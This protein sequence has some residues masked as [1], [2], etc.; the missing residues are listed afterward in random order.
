M[1]HLEF[2]AGS[3]LTILRSSGPSWDK[4]GD[5]APQEQSHE[6]GPCSIV[7]SHGQVDLATDGTA[8][9]V[10]TIS[11]EAPPASDVR[12]TDKVRLPNGLVAMVVQPPVRPVNQFT[13][14]SPFVQFTLASP[15]YVTTT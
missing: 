11:V 14:W 1:S 7:D 9:W 10:G 13:G 6:I 2:D 12:V 8:R 3:T 15:G 5:R 4:L